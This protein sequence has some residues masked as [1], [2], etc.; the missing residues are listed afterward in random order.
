MLLNLL[1]KSE[2]P[3]RMAT[4]SEAALYAL[5]GFL[6]VFVGISFLILVIWLVK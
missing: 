1:A 3:Y 5:L 6:V 2:N 4:F